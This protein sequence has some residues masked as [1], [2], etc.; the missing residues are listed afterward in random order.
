MLQQYFNIPNI[1][2]PYWTMIIEM[3]FYVLIVIVYATN[4]LKNIIPIG[5]LLLY[6]IAIPNLVSGTILWSPYVWIRT[7]VPLLN[8]FALFFAGILF[9]KILTENKNRFL[10]YSLILVSFTVQITTIGD[11]ITFITRTEHICMIL[12]Y[13]ALFILFVNGW[14]KF[15]ITPITLFLGKISFALYLIHQYLSTQIILP[16]L[17]NSFGLG[18]WIAATICLTIIVL[19]SVLIT[20]YIEIP[21]GQKVNS[22]L[23]KRFRLAPRQTN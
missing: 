1:D 3:L 20:F 16:I 14:L 9:Y 10:Y 7:W 8:H 22:S 6:L 21:I 23:R 5:I 12:I 2:G 17:Q 18:F 19:L 13:F 11:S 15:L 4:G